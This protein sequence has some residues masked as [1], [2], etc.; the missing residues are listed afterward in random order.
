[1]LPSVVGVAVAKR[2]SRSIFIGNLGGRRSC[3]GHMYGPAGWLLPYRHR[4]S[5]EHNSSSPCDPNKGTGENSKQPVH[6]RLSYLCC[7]SLTFLLFAALLAIDPCSL[8]RWF[9]IS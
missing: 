5:L 6:S 4:L 1:M 2:A 7:H 8:Q 9:V 3:H